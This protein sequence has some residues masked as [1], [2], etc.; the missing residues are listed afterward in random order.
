MKIVFAGSQPSPV[1]P[2]PTLPNDLPGPQTLSGGDITGGYFG[3]VSAANFI[4]GEELCDLLGLTAGISQNSEAGWLK[5]YNNNEITYVAKMTFR[6]TISW[7]NINAVGAVFGNSV[8]AVGNHIF[9]CRLLSSAEWNKL[10]YPVHVNY[11]TW[12]SFSNTDLNI[13]GN[14]GYTWTSTLS[15]SVRIVRGSDSVE[16]SGGYYPSTA[17]SYFGFRPVLVYLYT[18]PS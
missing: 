12:A 13:T 11:G 16:Y 15:G 14:G 7:D 3:E 4:S 17:S 8:V 5:Y 6:H 1:M 18:L 10:I 2:E 9:A